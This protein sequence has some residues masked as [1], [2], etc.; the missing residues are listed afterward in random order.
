L[1]RWRN[2]VE[3]SPPRYYLN[4]KPFRFSY[5]AYMSS[6]ATKKLKIPKASAKAIP[7]NI[8]AV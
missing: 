6:N 2:P 1:E 7:I 5:I 8:V 3:A 4:W